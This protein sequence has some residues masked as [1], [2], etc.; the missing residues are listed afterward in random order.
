MNSKIFGIL[1]ALGSLTL[2]AGITTLSALKRTWQ[3][4]D[5]LKEQTAIIEVLRENAKASDEL[6]NQLTKSNLR[7]SEDLWVTRRD[8]DK[9]KGRSDT[10][11]KKPELVEKMITESFDQFGKE[12]A[13]A[14]G[15]QSSC[16]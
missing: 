14:T 6:V 3:V 9:M 11:L 12:M 2:V 13:C 8:L 15:M 4:Q 1:L 7:M 5:Q 16:Q 10:V